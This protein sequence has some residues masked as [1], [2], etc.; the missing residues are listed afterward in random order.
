MDDHQVASH[1]KRPPVHQILRDAVADIGSPTT[2]VKLKD[3]IKA[4]Y[5]GIPIGTINAQR[6]ICTVNQP[7]R[8]H[9]PQN[10]RLRRSNDPRYDFL[11]CTGRGQIEWYRPEKHGNWIIERDAKG[12][13]AIRHEG[14]E[15]IYPATRNALRS[16]P[17][18]K[19]STHSS[20]IPLT[21]QQIDAAK[22]LH[23]RL[24]KWAATDRAFDRLGRQ[25]GWGRE[26][27]ILKAAVI[28]DLYSTRVYAIWRMAEHLMKVMMNPPDDPADV[29]EAIAS[30]P[31]DDGITRRKHWSFASK[32]GHFFI[33]GDK[34]PIYD[35]FCREMISYHLGG[36]SS[37]MDTG[38]PYR[39]FIVNLNHLRKIFGLTATLRDLDC[40]MWLAGQYR[41]W[42]RK[43][44]KAQI[45]SELRSIFE[46]KDPEVRQLLAILWPET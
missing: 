19:H 41:E 14:E 22:E 11:Y 15:L 33:N 46:D 17:K 24:I 32:I 26:S 35:S 5:P 2:N 3:W 1:Q 13:F 40:Y 23:H 31:D 7:S 20:T 25:F 27:C 12:L 39:T 18:R 44:D 9:Y 36:K 8:V 21:Q 43:H 34:Y 29:V 42:L 30:L 28:N 38:N 6:V 45:N 10:Q 37:P 4:H 16:H